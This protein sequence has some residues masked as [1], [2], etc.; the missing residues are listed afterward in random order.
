MLLLP[1][2]YHLRVSLTVQPPIRAKHTGSGDGLR[3]VGF[4]LS[5]FAKDMV[6]AND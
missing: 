6:P 3:V 5:S 2:G 4:R 1:I